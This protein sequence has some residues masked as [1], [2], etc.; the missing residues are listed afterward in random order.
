MSI[1]THNARLVC[2]LLAAVAAAAIASPALAQLRVSWWS[3]DGG[4]DRS[5]G[6]GLTVTGT[7]GQPDAGMCSGGGL[8]VSGGAWPGGAHACYPNCDGSTTSPVLNV[9]DFACFLNR[10]A[11][12]DLW[13]N[14]DNSTT[15]PVLNVLD[16]AC[17]LNNFAAGCP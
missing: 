3:V 7:I 12:A 4:A 16:F 1:S 9:L 17:F 13:A 11:A 6:S 10:F 5:S 8:T 14:C 15:P 2:S